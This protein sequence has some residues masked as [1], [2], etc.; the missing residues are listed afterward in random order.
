MKKL[1]LIPIV[2]LLSGCPGGN[3][4]AEYRQVFMQGDVI[5]FSVNKKDVLDYYRVDST[6]AEG[7][8][9]IKAEERVSLTY[10]DTCI[11]VK[12]KRGYKYNI[13]YGLN[14]KKYSAYF[15]IDN[16]GKL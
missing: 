6:Q 8:I 11:K 13:A 5:C 7:Y 4:A 16:N 15:F 14:G 1:S 3:P 2:F 12:L 10:P 9:I